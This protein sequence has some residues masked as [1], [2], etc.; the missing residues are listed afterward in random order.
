MQGDPAAGCLHLEHERKRP[1]DITENK[2]SSLDIP[3]RAT[4]RQGM[5][6]IQV[7]NGSLQA[8]YFS[9]YPKLRDLEP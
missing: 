9:K 7:K 1:K 6:N 4:A 8:D 3:C 2:T 5:S